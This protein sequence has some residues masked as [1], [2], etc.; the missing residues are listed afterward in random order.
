VQTYKKSDYFI[1]AFIV[2]FFWVSFTLEQARRVRLHLMYGD[3][4]RKR[5]YYH[6]PLKDSQM[7]LEKE[8]EKLQKP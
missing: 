6:Q 5:R 2:V 8:E 7:R 4:Q 3:L 1:G